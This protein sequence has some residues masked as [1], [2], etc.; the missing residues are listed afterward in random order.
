MKKAISV[1]SILLMTIGTATYGWAASAKCTV[2][3]NKGGKMVV[4]CG[5]RA[6]EI[7]KGTRIKIK[8]EKRTVGEER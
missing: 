4:A 6:K 7:A 8:T 1:L 3:D 5:E 2:L